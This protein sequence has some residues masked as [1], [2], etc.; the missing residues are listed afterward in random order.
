[1][2]DI[3]DVE[4]CQSLMS[5]IGDF[6]GAAMFVHDVHDF[7][8]C[9]F[10][11]STEKECTAVNG[12]VNPPYED[13]FNQSATTNFPT[14]TTN[15][16]TTSSS[17][18]AG[19]DE[20]IILFQAWNDINDDRLSNVTIITDYS[21]EELTT[22]KYGDTTLIIKDVSFPHNIS[23]Y[24]SMPGFTGYNG[25]RKI[26][27]FM[28]LTTVIMYM[29]PA[30]TTNVPI[31]NVSTTNAPTT[32]VS[33]TVLPTTIVSTTITPTTNVSTTIVPTTNVSTTI[34]PTT[35]VPT[36]ITPTT[37]V[38]TT[39]VPT[40]NVPTTIVPTTSV[41]TTTF[42]TSTNKPTTTSP[43]EYDE[44]IVWFKH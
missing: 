26:N 28:E 21:D 30:L 23:F 33:T 32:N 37:N 35:N 15:G 27:N 40:T 41:P 12:P 19:Y 42:S 9:A 22:D 5:Q 1:M 4:E 2:R 8:L 25:S 14:T 7:N 20:V 17:S 3:T 43:P 13:C 6:Y 44:V 10:L 24:A 36:T 31:T 34:V 38:S 16:L 11:S 29:S 39:N 18:S